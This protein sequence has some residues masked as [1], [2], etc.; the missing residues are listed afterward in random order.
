[1]AEAS[2]VVTVKPGPDATAAAGAFDDLPAEEVFPGLVRRTFSSQEATVNSYRF[3]PGA[4][5]PQHSHPQEQI[6]LVTGGTIEIDVEGEV[7][8]LADGAW[9]VIKGGVE[10]GITAGPEGASIVAMIVPRRQT[11]EDYEIAG[12]SQR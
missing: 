5:F 11:T 2:N 12:E 1:M 3:E 8:P 6:T 10:H 7:T 9:S 4:T